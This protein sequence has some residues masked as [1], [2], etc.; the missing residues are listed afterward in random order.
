M[1]TETYDLPVYWASALIN[2]DESGLSEEDAE[3][4]EG[5]TAWMIAHYGKCW[6]ID[7][8]EDSWFARSHD[9]WQWQ[10]LAGH[11]ATYTFDVT[12]EAA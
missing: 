10:P 8:S 4:L 12:P 2:G 1:Q 3:A 9:A 11:V 5:F 7:V 6:A